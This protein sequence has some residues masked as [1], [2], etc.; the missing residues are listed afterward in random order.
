[1]RV[2]LAS[3]ALALLTGCSSE[4]DAPTVAEASAALTDA[5]RLTWT[6]TSAPLRS[7]VRVDASGHLIALVAAGAPPFKPRSEKP[8]V[9]AVS[10]IA[11]C[12]PEG[13][14]IACDTTYSMDGARQPVQR[15]RYWR[16][17][18]QWRAHLAR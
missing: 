17:G 4:P 8:P 3:T 2:L 11:L 18:N 14:A 13:A 12:E 7:P 9:V 6:L 16:S 15:V 10:L 1:M 5:M